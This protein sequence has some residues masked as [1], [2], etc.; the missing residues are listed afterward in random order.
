MSGKEN[1]GLTIFELRKN[2]SFEGAANE[3]KTRAN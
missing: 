3:M 1:T 2:C